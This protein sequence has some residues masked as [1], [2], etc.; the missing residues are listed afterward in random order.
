MRDASNAGRQRRA[1][2][3]CGV[4]WVA[5][6]LAPGLD[7]RD[8]I[9]RWRCAAMPRYCL[10]TQRRDDTIVADDA[11]SA[12]P[13]YRAPQEVI[14]DFIAIVFSTRAGPPR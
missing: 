5:R 13:R 10:R 14:H 7:D 1:Y 2:R 3:Y 12:G 6:L 9:S 4:D 11:A 8:D